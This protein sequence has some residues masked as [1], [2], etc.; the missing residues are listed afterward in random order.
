MVL[1][2][3]DIERIIKNIHRNVTAN[4]GNNI[5]IEETKLKKVKTDLIKL[6]NDFI[7][8]ITSPFDW[9]I[10]LINYFLC[11][12]ALLTVCLFID[13]YFRDYVKT[14]HN[15]FY[16]TVFSV[17]RW[18]G[19][20]PLTIFTFVIFY[21][22]GLFKTKNEIRTIGIKI[23][24]SFLFSGILITIIKSIIG[25]Y[26][27]YTEN[28]SWSFVPFTLGPNEHLSFPSGDVAVAFA[29]SVIIAG[30]F[31]N[32]LWKIFWYLIAA[33]TSI[34]RIYY[35]RHWA[36]DVAAAAIITIWVGNFINKI[37]KTVV[38]NRE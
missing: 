14:I 11:F 38:E 35:D 25:R 29:F 37:N 8:L 28:G 2:V 21:L 30:I 20:P 4:R 6:K 23:F 19:K 22:G 18:Y 24:E 32:K 12:L 34:G 17:A 36:S 3:S 26:R 33:V 9:D 1:S 7:S 31:Q 27:P 15:N 5:L 13:E 10:D 16:D